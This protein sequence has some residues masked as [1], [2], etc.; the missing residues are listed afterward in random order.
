MSESQ[1]RIELMSENTLR[2][3][4]GRLGLNL[5]GDEIN[6]APAKAQPEPAAPSPVGRPSVATRG[7]GATQHDKPAQSVSSNQAT[8]AER[9]FDRFV[10]GERIDELVRTS[11]SP[12]NA[13]RQL[14]R[15]AFGSISVG[16][17]P[18]R[19]ETQ[20]LVSLFGHALSQVDPTAP[21]T[22]EA[23]QRAIRVPR[24]VVAW[25]WLNYADGN[26]AVL[27]TPHHEAGR[28]EAD[29]GRPPGELR[30][31]PCTPQNERARNIVDRYRNGDSIIRLRAR[32]TLSGSEVVDELTSA[33]LGVSLDRR[34]WAALPA[35]QA[36]KQ[37]RAGSLFEEH[38]D[39]DAIG[40]ELSVPD[41]H[42]AWLLVSSPDGRRRA[43]AV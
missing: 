29:G 33:L 13:R 35:E 42:V 40:D 43:L 11:D 5:V 12:G 17:L 37:Q 28:P 34:A 23:A 36:F 7:Q 41:W 20:R 30:A 6:D 24:G 22:L 1:L 10:A 21:A 14:L 16:T 39:I 25:L 26:R 31:W 8:P 3:L 38:G 32:F 19:A 2:S 15:G 9:L 4:L 27:A 18:T